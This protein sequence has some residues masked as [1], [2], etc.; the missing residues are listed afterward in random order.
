MIRVIIDG[1]TDNNCLFDT[2]ADAERFAKKLKEL[3][4]SIREIRIQKYGLINQ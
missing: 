2:F 4:P 3:V 1:K